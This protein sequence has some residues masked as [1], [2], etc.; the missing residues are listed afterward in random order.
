MHTLTHIIFKK[1][2]S[3]GR[4]FYLHSVGKLGTKKQGFPFLNSFSRLYS[5][6]QGAALRPWHWVV[7]IQVCCSSALA[8]GGRYPGVSNSVFYVLLEFSVCGTEMIINCD[9]AMKGKGML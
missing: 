1:Q 7:G 4:H 6:L 3:E 5:S 2:N 9:D 8:L